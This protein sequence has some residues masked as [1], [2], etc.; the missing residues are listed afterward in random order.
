MNRS[1]FVSAVSKNGNISGK[2]AYKAVTLVFETLRRS[3]SEGEDVEIGC[4]GTFKAE[5]GK[6]VFSVGIAFENAVKNRMK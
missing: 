3:I 4:F 6:P 2:Q 5:N 1:D